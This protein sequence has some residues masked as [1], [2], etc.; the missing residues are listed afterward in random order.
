MKHQ[1]SDPLIEWF[2]MLRSETHLPPG[3]GQR[4]LNKLAA[5]RQSKRQRSGLRIAA[6]VLVLICLGSAYL[7]YTS[8]VNTEIK[9]FYQTEF[10]FQTLIQ[11]QWENLPTD[12]AEFMIPVQAS[13]EQMKRL[14]EQYQIQMEKFQNGND[15][16]KL[17]NA[18]IT[19]LQKQL[20]I[21]QDLNQQLETLNTQ[22]D[23]TE[24][25]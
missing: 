7:T 9:Q 17:L 19:N 20:E 22:N 8:P 18:M 12:Q 15:H 25:L 16:P 1:N 2:E 4:F 11:K 14:Q 21:L 10:Y 6:M 13:K 3:H 5:E 23:E 24:L